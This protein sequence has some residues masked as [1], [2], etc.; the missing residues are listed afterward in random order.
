MCCDVCGAAATLGVR[1][2]GRPAEWFYCDAHDGRRAAAMR[3]QIDRYGV[4]G[5]HREL[6]CWDD[7]R[8]VEVWALFEVAS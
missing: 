7:T 4:E 5:V 2:D 6:R 3:R 8:E 1:F